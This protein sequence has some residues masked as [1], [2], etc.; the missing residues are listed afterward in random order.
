M[1]ALETGIWHPTSDGDGF[2]AILKHADIVKIKFVQGRGV[3]S[4]EP[5]L[6]QESQRLIEGLRGRRALDFIEHSAPNLPETN[7]T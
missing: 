4:L 1:A 6:R 2:W 5:W 3:T 7:F